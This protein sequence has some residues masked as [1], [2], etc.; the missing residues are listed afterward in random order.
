MPERIVPCRRG[1]WRALSQNRMI[2][3]RLP[4][5]LIPA[6]ILGSS[7]ATSHGLAQSDPV[8]PSTLA[9]QAYDQLSK[10]NYAAAIELFRKALEDGA[11]NVSWRKDLGY[12]Y[13]Q[14]GSLS[15]AA[16]EFETIQK[17]HPDDL[18]NTLELGFLY[19]QMARNDL[20]KKEFELAAKSPDPAISTRAAK[21]LENIRADEQ[22]K[23][24]D[25]GYW[26]LQK[27]HRSEAI[28]SFEEA[29]RQNMQDYAAAMQLG[30][31]YQEEGQNDKARQIFR[32][33]TDSPDPKVASQALS[34]LRSINGVHGLW[35]SSIYFAPFY[36]SRFGDE[37]NPIDA[38]VGIRPSRY[39]QPYIGLRMNRDTR[40]ETGR[41]PIIFADDTAV[42][43]LGVQSQPF[44][45]DSAIYAE[46]GTAMSLLYKPPGGRAIPD[47]RVGMDWF[48][49]WGLSL[50]EASR[51][52]SG[53]MALFGEGYFDAAFYS[54][55]GDNIIG[56]MQAKEG[57]TL[58]WKRPLPFQAFAAVNVVKDSQGDFYNNIIEIG[59]GFRFAPFRRM[60]AI[61]IQ[62]Q[63]LRGYYTMKGRRIVNPYGPSY[64]DCRIFV[65]WQR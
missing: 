58:P 14:Q 12:T 18:N 17:G 52:I 44:G 27:G 9:Q 8:L 40:S 57:L 15:S 3:F 42:L 50:A 28:S 32:A 11:D 55:Y 20:A 60:P 23:L 56:Y 6:L 36:A 7:L 41:L 30:Y 51:Q 25:Q 22:W 45:P 63:Y 43:A 2:R 46:A 54:R 47:Y 53:K 16:A 10:K 33:A 65:V 38:K 13:M 4:S 34:A 29:Y 21:A 62:A 26:L 49:A 37:I 48:R 61:Q 35:F 24:R 31:L 19:Y 64:D 39:F 59:P 1:K 5:A